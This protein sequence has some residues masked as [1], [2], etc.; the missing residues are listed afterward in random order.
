MSW[1]GG[2]LTAAT[3]SLTEDITDALAADK[4]VSETS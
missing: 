4:D 2:S 3:D 1:G